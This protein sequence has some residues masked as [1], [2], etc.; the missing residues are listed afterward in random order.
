M[1]RSRTI[2]YRIVAI[3]ALAGSCA[4]GVAVPDPARAEN[5]A[6]DIVAYVGSRSNME[7][8]GVG[9]LTFDKQRP[10]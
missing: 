8:H 9:K 7:L 5:G 1:N 6:K 10:R 3:L 2:R 4:A